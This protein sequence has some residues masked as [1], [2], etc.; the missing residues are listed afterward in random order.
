M[1]HSKHP[2]VQKWTLWLYTDRFKFLII[3][4]KS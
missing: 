2:N 4:L 3:W 1:G